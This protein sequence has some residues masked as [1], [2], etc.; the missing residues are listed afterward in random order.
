MSP[1][2]NFS[3]TKKSAK[4]KKY[5]YYKYENNMNCNRSQMDNFNQKTLKTHW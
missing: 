5:T 2:T 1:P 4:I 3:T